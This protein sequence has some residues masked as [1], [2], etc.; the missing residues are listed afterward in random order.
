MIRRKKTGQKLLDNIWLFVFA[1]LSS[2]SLWFFIAYKGQSETTVEAT[3]EFRN[4]P[5]GV[6]ILRQN[7]KKVNLH[8]RGPERQIKN[9]SPTELKVFVDLSNA[10]YGETVYYFDKHNIG[11][12]KV[13]K[14]LK[15]EPNHVKM[16]IDESISKALPVRALIVGS[17]ERGY[18]V[19][20]IKVDPETVK[21]EGPKSEILKIRLLKTE[22]I[23]IS[24]IDSGMSIHAKV[25]PNGKIVRIEPPEVLVTINLTRSKR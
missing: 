7:I 14:I 6:E 3:I 12:P 16:F 1:L 25:N 5:K 2:L 4:I 9:L 20:S 10:K 21:I 24:G 18:F 15:I 8:I 13:L 17:P 22:P 23:E 19:Q 11:L